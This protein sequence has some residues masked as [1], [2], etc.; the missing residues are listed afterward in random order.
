MVASYVA[1]GTSAI[2]IA[3]SVTPGLPAGAQAGD[4]IVIVASV[5][6]SGTGTVNLPTNWSDIVDFGNLRVMVRLYD[7][8]W[9]MPTITFTGATAS[10]T[11]IGQSFAIR[12]ADPNIL[13]ILSG[14]PGTV[15]NASAQNIA[16]P[17]ITIPDNDALVF[18]V[19]WKQ[20]DWTSITTPATYT[21]GPQDSSTLGDDAAQAIFYK[22]QDATTLGTGSLTVTGGAAAIS[23]S[24]VFAF[25]S[26]P[27]F[28]AAEQSV[29]PPR[30]LLTITGLALGDDIELFRSVGGVRTAVRA[31]SSTDVTDTSFIVVDAELPFGVPV[32]YVAVVNGTYEYETGATTYTLSGGNVAATDAISGLAAEVKILSWPERAYER[33]ATVFRVGGRNV[34]VAGDLGQPESTIEL[35]VPDT[36]AHEALS[37]LLANATEAI[38]HIRQPGGYD[39]IDSY[40]AVVRASEN[41]LVLRGS[42]EARIWVLRVAETEGWASSFEARGYTYAD[43]EA[44]Y[45][46]LTYANLAADYATYLALAQADLGA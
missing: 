18:R 38:I 21:A 28:V 20:D 16:T 3:T 17:G 23:R 29:W 9:T 5:R 13:T 8:V 40:L 34:V 39:G 41:R 31:G 35:Y 37:D 33:R 1:A 46:G 4:Y 2:G 26:E 27:V 30:V 36:D 32:S 7:G 44:A 10:A 6:N 25:R 12:G 14:T 11:T 42:E 19:A 22:E 45:T 15:L 43:L 24:V